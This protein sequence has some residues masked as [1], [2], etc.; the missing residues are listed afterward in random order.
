MK[1]FISLVT[2]AVLMTG[3]FFTVQPADAGIFSSAEEKR[4]RVDLSA[5][6]SLERLLA[7][8]DKA[9][10]LYDRAYGYAIFNI[11]KGALIV[12][13]GGGTGVAVHKMSDKRT[14]M[15]MGMGG[16]GLGIGGQAFRLVILF[17]DELTFQEFISDGW[18]ASSSAN[19]VAGRNGANAEASFTNGIAVYQ[20]TDAGLLLQADIAGSRYW[21][22]KRL[23]EGPAETPVRT[24][25]AESATS[26]AD[27]TSGKSVEYDYETQTTVY[28]LET[29]Q[30][31]TVTEYG[32]Q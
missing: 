2:A 11:T 31:E 25:A 22:S 10:R 26:T 27:Y 23:N 30:Y 13:G 12:T 1:K 21:R 24:A 7:G 8:D 28:P 5:K 17:E 32:S 15:H 6:H 16:V 29:T 18:H 19:A 4:Q 14:Y 20:L 9:Q 3:L